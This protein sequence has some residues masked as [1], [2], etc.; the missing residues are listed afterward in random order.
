MYGLDLE[1]GESRE[2]P[3]WQE[4][5]KQQKIE[6]IKDVIV[7]EIQPYIELDAGGVEV[8]DL[9]G[10][11]EVIIAYSGSCTT[12]YSATG[13]TLSAIQQILR[14]KVWRDLIVTPKLDVGLPS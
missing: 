2:W 7:K 6:V 9:I 13:A 12:C 5:T 10:Q 4:L 1:K 8:L 3:G 14:A 11:R